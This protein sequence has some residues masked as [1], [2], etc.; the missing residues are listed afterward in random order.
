MGPDVWFQVAMEDI[1]VVQCRDCLQQL[2]GDHL[3][4]D[5]GLCRIR[6]QI[7][8]EIT[9]LDEFHCDVDVVRVFEPSLERHTPRVL[10]C[11]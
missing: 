11:R 4:F 7:L 5:L 2:S 10:I 3:G 8:P 6:V 1:F 9:V